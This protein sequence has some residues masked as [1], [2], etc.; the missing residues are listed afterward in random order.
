[1]KRLSLDLRAEFPKAEGFSVVNLYYI[2]RWFAFYSSH[3]NFFYQAG[4]KLQEVKDVAS[5]MPEILLS[6]PW[7]HQTVIVS[8][9]E[10]IEEYYAKKRILKI[11]ILF[12]L[13]IRMGLEPITP[14]LK[15]LCSTSWASG[16]PCAYVL[17]ASAKLRIFFWLCKLFA[18]FLHIFFNRYFS[19]SLLLYN[20]FACLLVYCL[21]YS[22]VCSKRNNRTRG[23]KNK[24]IGQ[25][26]IKQKLLTRGRDPDA[27]SFMVKVKLNFLF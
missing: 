19:N 3:T 20:L 5:P 12:F 25:V 23:K 10:T 8:K 2:K 13:V 7:R 24:T 27:R 16:S 17:K 18:Y 6:V 4:K 11:S 21:P 22:L 1:M 9:C 14:T 26:K 15:V